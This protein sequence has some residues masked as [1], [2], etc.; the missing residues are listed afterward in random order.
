MII[1]LYIKNVV[2]IEN[3]KITFNKGL[4]V[5]TGETGAGKS[6]ILDALSMALGER[7]NYSLI[8]LGADFAEVIAVFNYFSKEIEELLRNNDIPL[9]NNIVLKRILTK[10]NKTKAYVNDFSVSISFLKDLGSLLVDMHGQFENNKLLDP[11]N[12]ILLLDAFIDNIGIKKLTENSYIEYKAVEKELNL[13]RSNEEKNQKETE[14]I[15]YV[16]KELEAFSPRENEELELQ[17]KKLNL[18]NLNKIQESIEEVERL[19]NGDN[20]KDNIVK[21]INYVDKHDSLLENNSNFSLLK[22]YLYELFDKISISLETFKELQEEYKSLDLS[23]LITIEARLMDLRSLASKHKVS[24]NELV[25]LIAY[26]KS[27]LNNIL[28][29][30][31]KIEK[32]SKELK[33]K[34]EAYI[35]YSLQLSNE[36]K[37]AS[38]KLNAK[39]LS[40][41]RLLKLDHAEFLTEVTSDINNETLIGVDKVIF[42]VKTNLGGIWGDL[43]KLASGGEMSRIMLALKMILST[44]NNIS[45]MILDEIDTGVSGEVANAIGECLLNL[46]QKVQIILVTHSHQIASKA[47]HHL[48][49]MKKPKNNSTVTNIFHLNTA[50]R[51]EEI[52]RMLSGDLITEEAKSAAM[53]LLKLDSTIVYDK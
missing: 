51:I 5:L 53:K 2:L 17:T 29:I 47:H 45:T 40:E 42:K 25:D 3:L 41:L 10:D 52:A 50:E 44:T 6:I 9:N 35:N 36:R 30:S 13:L 37:K 39:I 16:L 20:I 48:Y 19:F 18:K 34:K 27:K 49:I 46:S 14:Y 11:S 43:N 31:D 4:T 23:E 38:K 12:H 33:G 22:K 32:L 8:S 21:S 1:E 24:P 7:A 28:D 26:Y 15:E